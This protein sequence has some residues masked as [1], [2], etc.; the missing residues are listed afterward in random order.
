MTVCVNSVLAM[1]GHPLSISLSLPGYSRCEKHIWFP[2]SFAFACSCKRHSHQREYVQ[3][4][5]EW[6][7][8][9]VYFQAR[10]PN[11]QLSLRHRLRRP[12]QRFHWPSK[13]CCNGAWRTFWRQVGTWEWYGALSRGCGEY[14]LSLR[15]VPVNHTVS[16]APFSHTSWQNENCLVFVNPE[17]VSGTW[18]CS[19]SD[20]S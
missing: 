4:W 6:R 9:A 10:N 5:W 20:L 17:P 18:D 14:C 19:H 8:I 3:A 16:Y 12:C 7:V 13:Y 1:R 15:W 11:S 2:N